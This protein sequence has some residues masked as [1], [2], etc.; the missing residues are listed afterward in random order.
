MHRS[1]RGLGITG[2]RG[3]RWRGGGANAFFLYLKDAV[4]FCIF[5]HF[6][7]FS[8]ASVLPS[9]VLFFWH[10]RPIKVLF[11]GLRRT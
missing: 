10:D 3:L 4:L 8:F 6:F 5:F 2:C 11:R 1:Q 9:V 7:H